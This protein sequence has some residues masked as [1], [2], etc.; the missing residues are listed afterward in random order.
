VQEPVW[1]RSLG[2]SM[3]LGCPDPDLYVQLEI[4]GVR[5]LDF[6]K[7]EDVFLQAPPAVDLPRKQ[8]KGV[9]VEQGHPRAEVI[10]RTSVLRT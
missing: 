2:L 9:S 8:L 6:G 1:A 7:I 5:M 10:P 3:P 4:E